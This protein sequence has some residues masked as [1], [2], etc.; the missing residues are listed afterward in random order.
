MKVVLSGYYGFHNVGDEAILQSIIHAL[1]MEHHD[2][3]I[4]VLSNNPAYTKKVYEVDAVNRWKLKEVMKAIHSSDG[5]ISGG[6]SLL[7]DKTGMKSVPYYTGIMMMARYVGK[8]FFVYAQGVGPLDRFISQRLVKFTLS[9]AAYLSVRDEESYKLLK[10]IGIN[11]SIDIVP[12]PVMGMFYKPG[13]NQSWI[14]NQKLTSPF[15]TVAIRDWPSHQDFKQKMADALLRC[16]EQGQKIVFLPM[17]GEHDDIT[18]RE[19]AKQMDGN[20]YIFPFD[21]SIEE[22]I[23]LIGDSALLV[24]MRLHALIFAAI[25]YTPMIG[26]SYDPKIDSFIQQTGQPLIGHVDDNWS[27]DQLY[28]MIQDQLTHHT[29]QAEALKQKVLPLQ[30][31]ANETAKKVIE[32]LM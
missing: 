2:I 22:K 27:S 19:M 30:K 8:P 1:R 14:E 28:T 21:A 26:L 24:G 3:H 5:V 7:Q 10:K 25:A 29:E 6:G 13:L 12:D 18:S 9:K 17:H 15:I 32:K 4:T 31:K 11:H 20:P 23:S 16:V